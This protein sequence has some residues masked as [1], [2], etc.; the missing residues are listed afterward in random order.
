MSKLEEIELTEKQKKARS[1]RNKA[2]AFILA[3][4]VLVFYLATVFKFGP[5]LITNRPL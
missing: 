1:S 5:N 2:I 4:L 3:A